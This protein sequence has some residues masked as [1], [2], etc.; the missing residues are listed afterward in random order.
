MPTPT[1]ELSMG[2]GKEPRSWRLHSMHIAIDLCLYLNIGKFVNYWLSESHFLGYSVN[3]QDDSFSQQ[4]FLMCGQ[5]ENVQ[6]SNF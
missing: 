4:D 6:Q 3:G 1:L 5:V 2:A